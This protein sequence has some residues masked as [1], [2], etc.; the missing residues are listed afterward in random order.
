[1]SLGWK[2][3]GPRPRPHR[4]LVRSTTLN[5]HL[6]IFPGGDSDYWDL[7]GP[8]TEPMTRSPLLRV[9][10]CPNLWDRTGKKMGN[11]EGP[12]T[13]PRMGPCQARSVPGGRAWRGLVNPPRWP[14]TPAQESGD[15]HPRHFCTSSLYEQVT[16]RRSDTTGTIPLVPPAL[17]NASLGIVATSHPLQFSRELG[18]G[19]TA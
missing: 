11:M 14:R 8:A 2:E 12:T 15:G 6:R 9:L 5:R 3:P 10:P 19:D 17:W 7:C 1:M 4:R 18:R 16:R 13:G